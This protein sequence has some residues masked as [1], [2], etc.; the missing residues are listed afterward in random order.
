MTKTRLFSYCNL[1][2]II[3]QLTKICRVTLLL[4]FLNTFQARLCLR[5]CLQKPFRD[6]KQLSFRCSHWDKCSTVWKDLMEHWHGDSDPKHK[7]E[8]EKKDFYLQKIWSQQK[9]CNWFLTLKDH[10]CHVS[11][12]MNF[13][14]CVGSHPKPVGCSGSQHLHA[15]DDCSLSILDSQLPRNI[16]ANWD[17]SFWT[18]PSP[19]PTPK[20]SPL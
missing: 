20:K 4:G 18:Q 7:R 3:H 9:R 10:F 8:T 1:F 19:S 11:Y 2:N 12:I 16:Y 14:S 17:P 13:G 5:L 6:K 15:S